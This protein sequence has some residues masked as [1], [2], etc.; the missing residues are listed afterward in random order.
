MENLHYI[1]KLFRSSAPDLDNVSAEQLSPETKAR[2]K[3]TLRN[4]LH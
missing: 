2:L 3:Q 4:Q 1:R